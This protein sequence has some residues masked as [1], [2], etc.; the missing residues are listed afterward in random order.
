MHGRNAEIEGD[1]VHPFD[2]GGAEERDHVAETAAEHGQST[3][4]A[5]AEIGGGG[6]GLGIAIDAEDGAP[7]GVEDRPGIPPGAEGGVEIGG[8]GP[9]RDGVEDLGQHHR[10]M[11]ERRGHEGSSRP[12]RSDRVAPRAR[13]RSKFVR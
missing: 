13:A 3:G 6:A 9:R 10:D 8:A 1:A 4:I 7:R 2:A 11:G 12:G 5:P